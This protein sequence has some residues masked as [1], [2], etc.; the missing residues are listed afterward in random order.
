MKHSLTKNPSFCGGFTDLFM[1]GVGLAAAGASDFTAAATAQTSTLDALAIGDR[2]SD[3]HVD[4]I[5]ALV[6]PSLSAATLSVGHTGATT[7]FI[8]TCNCFATTPTTAHD[9]VAA[10]VPLTRATASGNL[11]GTWAAT[12]ANFDAVTAGEVWIW[13][14][15]SRKADRVTLRTA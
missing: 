6:G 11:L 7:A 8:T 10:T 15:I 3:V 14:V 2:V 5:T 1:L 9:P 4:V 12:G 13:A